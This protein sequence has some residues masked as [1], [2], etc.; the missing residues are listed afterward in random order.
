[1][2]HPDWLAAFCGYL[3]KLRWIPTSF[4][5]FSS[6]FKLY[7]TR[8]IVGVLGQHCYFG[9]DVAAIESSSILC[10][11]VNQALEWMQM[12][13]QKL[14][15]CATYRRLLH[16]ILYP[17]DAMSMLLCS[18]LLAKFRILLASVFVRRYE[19]C[20]DGM[21]SISIYHNLSGRLSETKRLL[22]NE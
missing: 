15:E 10:S 5:F 20:L 9:D 1:M 3:R 13:A 4:F 7:W 17:N 12:R 22:R 11:R 6:S 19:C 16:P 14:D 2:Q 21:L 8:F 18:F